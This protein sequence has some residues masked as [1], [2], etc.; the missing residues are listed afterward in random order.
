MGTGLI[1]GG[2]R[3]IKFFSVGSSGSTSLRY[4]EIELSAFSRTSDSLMDLLPNELIL[5]FINPLL[6][7]K[8]LLNLYQS[9]YRMNKLANETLFARLE[10]SII[11]HI[12]KFRG[13]NYFTEEYAFLHKWHQIK[14][15][16]PGVK[17]AFENVFNNHIKNGRFGPFHPDEMELKAQWEGYKFMFSPEYGLVA[18]RKNLPGSYTALKSRVV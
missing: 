3:A 11:A 17:N 18:S 15:K 2:F 13:Q 8:S 14:V 12:N 5:K 10:S 7:T 16:P 6:D 1:G 9:S 4:T